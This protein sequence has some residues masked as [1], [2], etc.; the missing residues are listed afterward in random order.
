MLGVL[1][2]LALLLILALLAQFR[3][4]GLLILGLALVSLAGA[5]VVV[6]HTNRSWSS[7]ATKYFDD[8]VEAVHAYQPLFL[9]HW[10]APAVS[11][12]QLDM[13]I[14]YLEK[15]ELPFTVIVRNA[16][17][18]EAAKNSVSTA[19]VV[20]A[21]RHTEMERLL[22]PSVTTVFYVNNGD[23][24]NQLLRFEHLQHI[25]LGHGDSDK[26][27]SSTRTFRL[28]DRIYVAGQAGLERFEENKLRIPSSAYSI[29]GRPQVAG[30]EQADA[31]ISVKAHLTVL[32]APT[33]RG[34]FD[35]SSHSSLPHSADLISLLLDMGC[36]V[37]F[38]PHP[39]TSRFQETAEAAEEIDR[40]LHVDKGSSGTPH[41]FGEAAVSDL[42]LKECFNLSDAMIADVSA[43]LTDYLYS[44][45]PLGAFVPTGSAGK[46]TE[47]GWYF[48]TEEAASWPQ[49]LNKLLSLDP[50]RE[51][52]LQLRDHRL[53][54][55]SVSPPDR[56]FVETAR[57]HVL[58]PNQQ[59]PTQ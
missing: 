53:G 36:R 38:R 20:L 50:L 19:P 22:V 34:D 49:Q 14:P 23:R 17:S 29:V 55:A 15:T 13:W 42:S 9:I 48:F 1:L 25:Q 27:T 12:Y 6:R 4:Y 26:A 58:E 44:G 39:F 8:V 2:T 52:R 57:I 11:R 21:Q 10:D 28:F 45:K 16:N 41:V 31:P 35:N 43:V 7:Q 5:L 40:R 33:W 18:F 47:A 59:N 32:Y 54:N 56:L 46:Q 24:N 30:I 51:S 37:I 3:L